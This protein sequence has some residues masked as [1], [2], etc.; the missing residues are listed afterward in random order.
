MG[1][2]PEVYNVRL[3]LVGKELEV[4][5]EVNVEV[6]DGVI[7]HIGRGFDSRGTDFRTG[8]MMPALVNAH[9]HTADFSFPEVGIDRPIA[10]LVGDPNSLKYSILKSLSSSEVSK[11]IADFLEYSK[12]IGVRTVIDFREQ[13]ILGSKVAREVKERV[14][15]ITY[16]VLGR[17]DGEISEEKLVEL[18]KFADG[19]GVP[20]VSGHKEAD[21][22][23]I[24]EVFKGKI[25]AVHFA[26]TLKQGLRDALDHVVSTL[27]PDLIIHGTNLFFDDFL[28]LA[29]QGISVVACP[30]SNLWFSVGV[31]R[32]DE[33][34][35]SGVNLLLGT[36]NGAWISPDIWKEMETALL[37]TRL[38]R[39]MSNFSKEILKA[40]TT[41]VDVLSIKNYIEEGNRASFVIIDGERTGIFRAKDIYAGIIKRGNNVL[42]SRGNPE[43]EGG[44][45]FS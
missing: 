41:N 21:L 3:A 24:G 27:S 37:V 11:G 7:T 20:S 2:R 42:Y 15:E 13:G 40:V 1:D 30:R 22:R 25:V 33:M 9:V 17:L 4:K 6:V 43:Y 29:Q 44:P 35:E 36:D 32:I 23:S 5:E 45:V 10:E 19:Y 39:P 18:S 8:I 14:K 38:R 28:T 12:G 26:E 31:P 34:I 16:V